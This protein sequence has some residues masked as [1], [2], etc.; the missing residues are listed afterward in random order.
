MKKISLAAMLLTIYSAGSVAATTVQSNAINV[1]S[2]S[3][4]DTIASDSVFA[5][6][7][8]TQSQSFQQFNANTGV[9]TGVT[10]GIIFNSGTLNLSTSGTQSSNGSG[11]PQLTVQ[12]SVAIDSTLPGIQLNAT[13]SLQIS[14]TGNGGSKCFSA[15]ISVPITGT[16]NST[17]SRSSTTI[18]ANSLNNY[19]GGSTVGS[20]VTVSN[21]VSASNPKKIDNATATLSVPAISGSQTLSY[22][23]LNH[24]NASFNNVNNVDVLNTDVTNGAISF[25]VSNL[26]TFAD[27]AKLGFLGFSC[28]TGNCGAFSPTGQGSLLLSGGESFTNGVIGFSDKA[29]AG[30]YSAKFGLLFRDYTTGASAPNTLFDNSLILNVNGN[31]AVAAVPEPETYLM[32]LAGLSVIGFKISRRKTV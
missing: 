9:L 26:G 22:S 29:T 27:T 2:T 3:L 12:G 7:S 16:K 23:Y 31:V 28:I 13:D 17:W 25:S 14:C 1:A 10:S 15:S 8:T 19:V 11:Q 20:T 6:S 32:L 18:D 24:A 5:N 4:T 21:K 30:N